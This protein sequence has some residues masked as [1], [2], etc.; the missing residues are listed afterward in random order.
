MGT[1][2]ESWFHILYTHCK[3]KVLKENGVGSNNAPRVRQQGNYDLLAPFATRKV[4]R[5]LVLVYC[6][7]KISVY[8]KLNHTF[9]CSAY[10]IWICPWKEFG[11]M[12]QQV[13][14][15][16]KCIM[17]ACMGSIRFVVTPLIIMFRS[18]CADLHATMCDKI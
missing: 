17:M 6:F 18:S 8:L 12:N 5:S 1:K 14:C 4:C 3:C 10:K 16:K 9:R 13:C 7:I 11:S 2:H 15:F